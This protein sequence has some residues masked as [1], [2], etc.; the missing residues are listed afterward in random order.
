VKRFL[1][2]LAF[3]GSFALPARATTFYVRQSVGNDQNGGTTASGTPLQ[4]GTD[5][6]TTS[7][8]RNFSAATGNFTTGC[9]GGSCAGQ[10]I[11]IN[12]YRGTSTWCLIGSVTNATTVVL[13]T[14]GG[15]TSAESGNRSSLTWKVGG[16]W[17]TITAAVAANATA[18][19]SG[20]DSVYIGAGTYRSVDSM[21]LTP[22]SNV[23]IAGDVDGVQ[24]GDIGPVVW[25]GLRTNDEAPTSASIALTL[26]SSSTSNFTIKN[27]IFQ[28]LGATAVASNGAT[29]ATSITLQNDVFLVT[30]TGDAI[31][32][33]EDAS[34][35]LHWTVDSCVFIGST[36]G[37][38]IITGTLQ[39]TADIDIDFTVKNSLFVDY[40]AGGGGMVR[41]ATSG[42]GTNKPGGGILY[43]NTSGGNNSTAFLQTTANW[44]TTFPAK[45][46]N[47]AVFDQAITY[48]NAG[49]SGNIVEDYSFGVM[50]TGTQRVNTTAGKHGVAFT[51]N[52]QMLAAM[53]YYRHLAVG[54]RMRE[55]YV[56]LDAGDLP[57]GMGNQAGSPSIDIKGLPRPTGTMKFG[58]EGTATS[59]AA[60]TITDTGKL[61]GTNRWKNGVVKIVGGT[62]SGQVK[63]IQSNTAT[64]ITVD[65][66]WKTN[67][68][69]TSA[70]KVYFGARATM[71][72]C[73]AG[74]T[75]TC[76]D[77]NASWGVNQWVGWNFRTDAGSGSG[78]TAT[79]LSNTATVLT[80]NETLTALDNTTTYAMFR[81]TDENT[82]AASAGAFERGD[83]CFRQT[84][85]T[86]QG[87]GGL[88]CFGPATQDFDVAVDSGVSTTV[89]IWAQWD[90]FYAGTK[91]Q[92]LVVNGTECGV[93]NATATAA[94]SVAATWE[95]LTLT[96]TPTCRGLI[97][98]R[99]QSNSTA[100]TGSA[101]FDDWTESPPPSGS[102][103]EYTRRGDL[104]ALAIVPTVPRNRIP[105]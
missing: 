36:N 41:L 51:G 57:L 10:G 82:P 16:A 18:P 3:L 52:G 81:G 96:F 104:P 55:P 19:I 69:N 67:P 21:N 53:E 64:A 74:S 2:V 63:Q 17:A 43:N 90:S 24:T 50:N 4:N 100:T 26:P 6:V 30:G 54:N 58:D 45:A 32:I 11:F 1:L 28:S 35:V 49:T 68:D 77:G 73:T 99:F 7:G 91:P 65:G 93:S 76:T 39:N 98:V 14:S 44:S 72:T 29:A 66:N 59:G 13:A 83:T 56:P 27:I 89:G 25:S 84:T 80:F 20:G 88:R 85:T 62:G 47:N 94:G 12:L 40:R 103:D 46:Y 60:T 34:R 101:Y 97:T 61:W 5:G 87:T 38:I 48:F 75:T 86:H 22:V 37:P 42:A 92:L 70:Y 15:C 23:T 102:A 79:V 8:T 33:T 31:L 78:Q 9:S 95:Q 71:G 105:Q